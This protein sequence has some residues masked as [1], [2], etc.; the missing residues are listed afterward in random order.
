MTNDAESVAMSPQQQRFSGEGVSPLVRYRELVLGEGNWLNLLGY[1]LYHLLFAS[2]PGM[3]GYG[4][5]SLFLPKLLKSGGRGAMVGK[6]V[7]FR[8]P[9]RIELGRKVMLDDYSVLDVRDREGQI[10]SPSIKLGDNCFIGRQSSIV[11]KGGKVFLGNACNVSSHC[12]IATESSIEI[13]E[14]VLIASY[15]YIGPGNHQRGSDGRVMIEGEMEIKGGV[16]IGSGSWIAT[17]ATI[18]DGVSIGK[19]VIV[20]AHSLVKDDV[21]D[22]A[23]VAGTPAKIIA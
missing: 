18:L 9:D 19:N 1:E 4:S 21:P 15:V 11:A 10:E 5:R 23:V 22:G 14:S 16:K 13:G 12:R 3:V 20:G 2:L 8:Q 17:R 7:L 6:N